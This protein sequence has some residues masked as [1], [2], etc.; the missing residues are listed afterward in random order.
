MQKVTIKKVETD[1]QKM[2]TE[3]GRGAF[4]RLKALYLK[5]VNVVDEDGAPI[6]P[7]AIDVTIALPIAA[8]EAEE[9]VE[10]SAKAEGDEDEEEDEEEQEGKS[11]SASQVADIVRKELAKQRPVHKAQSM[12]KVKDPTA[13]RKFGRKVSN[14]KNFAA[15]EDA[16]RFGRWC[17]A[18]YGHGKSADWCKNNGIQ[19]KAHTE[20]VNAAGGYLVPDEFSSSLIN[21][22]EEYGVARKYSHIEPMGSDVKRIPRRATGLTAYW[23]GEASATTESTAAFD[24]V[25]LVAKKLSCITTTS[26]E[27][28]E[29]SLVNIGDFIAGEIAYQFALKEDAALF[30][31]DGT[32][33]HGG[34]TGLATNLP[35]AKAGAIASTTNNPGAL[36]LPNLTSAMQLLPDFANN[37]NTRFYMHRET[38]YGAFQRLMYAAGGTDVSQAMAAPQKFLGYEVV[39]T[40]SMTAAGTGNWTTGDPIYYFGDMSL[41]SYFGDRR[42]TSI[43][44]SDSALNAFEQDELVIRGTERVDIVTTNLGSTTAGDVGAMVALTS[45]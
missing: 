25:N 28:Q 21:L 10:E 33:T 3:H 22:R 5:D 9:V 13:G 32:S 17:F 44:F 42:A 16:Y 27:L 2:L 6:D 1:L 20:G 26:S 39:F 37:A 36:T 40:N 19:L 45:S 34:I 23:T 41:V 8:D 15:E 38:W 18:A 11:F 14:V 43:A 29:D 35:V 4:P 12:V 7:E 31:G 30:V 24:Q